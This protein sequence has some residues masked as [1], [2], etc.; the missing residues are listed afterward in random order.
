MAGKKRD[1]RTPHNR[2]ITNYVGPGPLLLD[3]F[4]NHI[5]GSMLPPVPEHLV[6]YQKEIRKKKSN[7]SHFFSVLDET[8]GEFA[9][10]G[11]LKSILQK[12]FVSAN[13]EDA[14]ITPKFL[15]NLMEALD[16]LKDSFPVG[17]PDRDYLDKLISTI[18]QF[19]KLLKNK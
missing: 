13:I 4:M 6:Q 11:R 2:L 15:E 12:A 16:G 1:F 19:Y 17:G 8:F 7:V 9:V 10:S 3:E 5:T 18:F 14:Q